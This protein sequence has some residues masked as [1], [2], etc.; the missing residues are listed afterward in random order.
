MPKRVDLT[1]QKF[2]RLTFVRHLG[3]Q[4]WECLCD[5]G[6]IC[7]ANAVNIK[8]GHTKSCG[9]WKI[10]TH[11]THEMTHSPEY[12]AW[13][14]ITGRCLNPNHPNW[15]NYGGR[16]IALYP[17]W[18]SRGGFAAFY[19]YVG[20]RPSVKHTIERTDN[21]K[22]YEPGNVEW[23]TMK[24]QMSNTRQTH[25]IEIDGVRKTLRDWAR[26]N[27][28]HETTVIHRMQR[29]MSERDAIFTPAR[30]S[31]RRAS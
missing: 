8:N 1:G 17:A 3:K 12:A 26:D 13:A 29:G 20:P 16:G 15:N 5:C 18:T 27:D 2:N 7:R 6:T 22:G 9:C 30:F 25:W 14:N 10:E 31:G 23:A 24:R 11:R 19:A 28:I 4:M 21:S